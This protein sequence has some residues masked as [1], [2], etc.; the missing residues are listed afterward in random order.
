MGGLLVRA[1]HLSSCPRDNREVAGVRELAEDRAKARPVAYLLLRGEGNRRTQAGPAMSASFRRVIVL[2]WA[3]NVCTLD[4][5]VADDE[6]VAMVAD[7]NR[8]RSVVRELGMSGSE[9]DSNVRA[10]LYWDSK[11]PDVP[12]GQE[13]LADEIHAL[14]DNSRLSAQQA[15]DL[16]REYFPAR[17][18]P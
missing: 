18:H 12:V 17:G 15:A 5:V 8:L 16:E 7:A 14:L 3:S 13:G 11:V 6:F 9:V 2:H 4:L 1:A 10:R